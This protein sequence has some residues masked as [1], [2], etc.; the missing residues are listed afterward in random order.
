MYHYLF[1]KCIYIATLQIKSYLKVC[2]KNSNFSLTFTILHAIIFNYF[3]YFFYN[4]TLLLFINLSVFC[5]GICIFSSITFSSFPA[6]LST[7]NF[8]QTH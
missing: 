4:K 2:N 8:M 1:L 5:Y 7:K 3:S 6:D